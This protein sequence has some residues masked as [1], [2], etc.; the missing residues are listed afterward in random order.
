M[1]AEAYFTVPSASRWVSRGR[2][3]R[4]H[5]HISSESNRASTNLSA[6]LTRQADICCGRLPLNTTIDTCV[7]GP[8]SALVAI[9]TTSRTS[10]SSHRSTIPDSGPR[11]TGRSDL[12]THLG[13]SSQLSSLRPSERFTRRSLPPARSRLSNPPPSAVQHELPVVRG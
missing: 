5:S 10:P 9:H 6:R 13:Q 1:K 11:S 8:P 12:A 3:K 7:S 2:F 4:S